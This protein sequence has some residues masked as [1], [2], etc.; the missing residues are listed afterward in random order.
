[1]VCMWKGVFG[2]TVRMD[3]AACRA[4]PY[5]QQCNCA[6]DQQPLNP[7]EQVPEHG[8]LRLR[9]LLPQRDA[10]LAKG[11]RLEEG[12]HFRGGQRARHVPQQLVVQPAVSRAQHGGDGEAAQCNGQQVGIAEGRQQQDLKGMDC[13]HQLRGTE[14]MDARLWCQMQP[15]TSGAA[16]AAPRGTGHTSPQPPPLTASRCWLHSMG[17]S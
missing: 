3:A 4:P 13:C 16:C 8:M 2:L 17:R 10:L 7:P 12:G 1:M 14:F 9:R 6:A 5:H 15:L 11:H